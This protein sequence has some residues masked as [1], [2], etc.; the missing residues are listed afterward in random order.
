MVIDIIRFEYVGDR[1]GKARS[2]ISWRE[3]GKYLQGIDIDDHGFRTFRKDRVARYLDGAEAVLLDPHP[4]PPVLV[5][6][7]VDPRPHIIF[8]GF[9]KVQR[10]ALEA[11][12]SASG[13][14]VCKTVT[15][16]CFYLVA[17]PNAGPTKVERARSLSAYILGEAQF[18]A[19][20]ATG[21]L[22]EQSDM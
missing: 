9:A 20:V 13:M 1:L 15:P 7:A 11:N 8:T 22:P 5:R 4:E 10:A 18:F 17:G 2:L 3:S 14:R 6:K 21:E 19:L 16:T 12:A